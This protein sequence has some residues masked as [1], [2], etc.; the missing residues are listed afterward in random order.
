MGTI[1]I[2]VPLHVD[3][4]AKVSDVPMANRHILDRMERLLVRDED[5][6]VRMELFIEAGKIAMLD[7]HVTPR[8]YIVGSCMLEAVEEQLY[9]IKRGLEWVSN[10]EL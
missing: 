7:E 4:H 8:E 10:P 5:P 2:P 3:V 9:I 6:F 1:A